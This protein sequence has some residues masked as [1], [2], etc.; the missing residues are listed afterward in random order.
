[1][2]GD[3]ATP[4]TRQRRAPR[5]RPG[6]LG[7]GSRRRTLGTRSRMGDF[8]LANGTVTGPT[9]RG[10]ES[11]SLLYADGVRAILEADHK[12]V[13]IAYQSGF[14]P[15]PPLHNA[16]EPEVQHVM[17]V[18]IAQKHAD[19]SAL[20]GSLFARMDRSVFQNARFQPAPDQTDQA[21]IT[22]AMLDKPENPV[23]T[24][25]PEEVLQIRLQHPAYHATGDDLV[26]GRQGMMGAELRPAAE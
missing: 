10:F 20:R 9:R 5:R 24:E 26:E 16:L 15:Q 6:T 8:R 21:R 12:V 7:G 1:M 4:V 18:E 22:D 14:A 2:G 3:H 17:K 11:T 25:T 19:R 13:D 23:G